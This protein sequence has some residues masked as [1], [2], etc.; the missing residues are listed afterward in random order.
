MRI[1]CGAEGVIAIDLSLI[2][3]DLHFLCSSS[4]QNALAR[5]VSL[6]TA[7]FSLI[8]RIFFSATHFHLML[9][10]TSSHVYVSLSLRFPALS[11]SQLLFCSISYSACARHI[12]DQFIVSFHPFTGLSDITWGG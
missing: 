9:S 12:M 6:N 10:P 7:H 2:F 5:L 8:I 11:V 3:I 1:F 4:Q